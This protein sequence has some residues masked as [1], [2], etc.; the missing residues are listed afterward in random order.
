MPSR[1]VYV[2][3]M[4]PGRWKLTVTG[5]STLTLSETTGLN[6]ALLQ[7]SSVTGFEPPAVPSV[8]SAKNMPLPDARRPP[9]S[10]TTNVLFRK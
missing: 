3:H 7:K 5:E 1:I 6:S 2:L 4:P 10:W 8:R 9:S